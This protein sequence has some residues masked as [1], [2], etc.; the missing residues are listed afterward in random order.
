VRLRSSDRYIA[1]GNPDD[2]GAVRYAAT[3]PV[4]GLRWRLAPEVQAFA[5]AG[6][7]FETPTL[8]EVAY[9]P[10]GVTG[11][12]TSLRPSR[13]TSVE[14]GLRG[15]HGG[16]VW[17]AAL[18]DIRTRDEI[19]VLTNGG[20][21]STFT[22][23]GRTRR[24]GLE[25]SG[26]AQWGPVHVVAAYTWLDAFYRDG[27][28]TCEASPCTTSSVAVAAGNRMPGI[29]RQQA[30]LRADWEPGWSGAVFSTELRH[31]G[32]VPVNDR[33]SDAAAGWTT[34]SLAARFRQNVGAWQVREFI[35][36]DN[37]ANRRYAGSVIVNEAGGRFFETAA[38]RSWL[39]GVELVRI[40]D[41]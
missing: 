3:T 27:F 31:S 12:N 1:T 14:A 24:R 16:A 21:R 35:R 26:D 38:G 34:V 23:A 39:V 13:S 29:A 19:V 15:R 33:N 25:L 37:I 28:L 5:S 17:T 11:L 10:S 22:N 8:N 9:Q 41:R 7:G 30:Y 32:A 6:R 2:S 4:L 20:G 18:F 40:F 36:V